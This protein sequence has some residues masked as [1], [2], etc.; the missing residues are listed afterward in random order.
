MS[1]S[2]APPPPT[3]FSRR[4]AP[5]V[6]MFN[7]VALGNPGSGK[8]VYLASLFKAFYVA[9]NRSWRLSTNLSSATFLA[10]VYSQVCDPGA[11]WPSATSRGDTRT[12]LFDCLARDQRVDHTVFRMSYLEY[13]GEIMVGNASEQEQHDL[14]VHIANAHAL[15]AM[16]DGVRVR[17]YLR[18]EHAGIKYFEAQIIPMINQMSQARCPAQ[19]VITKWDLVNEFGE[20]D[21]ASDEVR[22]AMVREGLM[23]TAD[24]A[25]LVNACDLEGRTLRL[26][27]VSA[28][29]EGFAAVDETG[30]VRKVSSGRASSYNVGLPLA[31]V[32]PDVFQM[33]AMALTTEE[34]LRIE[35]FAVSGAGRNGGWRGPALRKAMKAA[36]RALAIFW[37]QG[38]FVD[39]VVDLFFDWVARR[40]RMRS[41]NELEVM[42]AHS[43]LDRA[44]DGVLDDF[45]KEIWAL[46]RDLPSSVLR[47]GAPW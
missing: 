32:I 35:R 33:T 11:D 24:F 5:D 27:P 43:A 45:E 37:P 42:D 8:T 14:S 26:I 2:T 47:H 21:G 39:P 22:L 6:P 30:R 40:K 9:G 36:T 19:F 3:P 13:A 18:G 1:D 17:Q 28:V 16:L 38:A 23:G 41:N 4:Y 20:P 12:I 10:E 34:R 31:A 7:V 25:A 15:V 44:R 29:G 46:E